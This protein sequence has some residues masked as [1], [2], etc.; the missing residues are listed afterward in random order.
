MGGVCTPACAMG[1]LSCRSSTCSVGLAAPADACASLRPVSLA[2]ARAFALGPPPRLYRVKVSAGL[3]YLMSAVARRQTAQHRM[4]VIAC[5]RTADHPNSV[6]TL[7][8]RVPVG[9]RFPRLPNRP[10]CLPGAGRLDLGTIRRSFTGTGRAR[11]CRIP[12]LCQM[13][14]A[15]VGWSFIRLRRYR[16][17]SV[18]APSAL[19]PRLQTALVSLARNRLRPGG[20]VKGHAQQGLPLAPGPRQQ[21]PQCF[22]ARPQAAPTADPVDG[23]FPAFRLTG[24]AGRM[25]S[26][27]RPAPRPPA[28]ASEHVAPV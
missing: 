27:W 6:E 17:S 19:P 13:R 3:A 12:A 9:P 14:T 5:L 16:R 7:G 21:R 4:S 22:A 10:L 24:P 26:V 18:R 8:V 15:R 2:G 11:G 1:L 20:Q 25:P 23:S 28:W